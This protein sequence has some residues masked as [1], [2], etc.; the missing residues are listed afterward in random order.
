MKKTLCL[1]L[2]ALLMLGVSGCGSMNN[3]TKGGLI[4]GGGGAAIGAGWVI[5]GIVSIVA[6][7]FAI[8]PA[9]A[10]FFGKKK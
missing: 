10:N 8:L 3:A 7:A 6:G 5:G 4:G 2:S 9:C 1:L